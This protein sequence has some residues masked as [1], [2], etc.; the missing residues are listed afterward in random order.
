MAV[1]ATP[2]PHQVYIRPSVWE[3]IPISLRQDISGYSAEED[4]TQ[5]DFL[6]F[7]FEDCDRILFEALCYRLLEA[8]IPHA[9]HFLGGR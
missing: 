4:H 3:N 2:S 7:G 1:L 9:T 6:R 5:A 8:R